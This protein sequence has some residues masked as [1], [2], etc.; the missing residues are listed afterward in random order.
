M[1]IPT[2]NSPSAMAE[3]L[4]ECPRFRVLV[5]GKAGAG[6]SSLIDYAFGVDR[7]SVSHQK[8]GECDINFEIKSTRNTRF[9]AHDSMGFEPGHKETFDMAKMFLES[10][11]NFPV[12]PDI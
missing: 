3:I 12:I 8:R 6:K 4:D 9:V 7:N 11:T 5:V 10:R 1:A 2:Q